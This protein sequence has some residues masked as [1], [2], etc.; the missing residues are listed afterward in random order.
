M[1]FV[2]VAAVQHKKLRNGQLHL[3]RERSRFLKDYQIECEECD[4]TSFVA[5]YKEPTY[6][7]NCGRRVEVEKIESSE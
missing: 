6:C 2:L 4:E 1:V 5:A 3:K 7:P